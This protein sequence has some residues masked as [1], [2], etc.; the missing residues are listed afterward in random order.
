MLVGDA[1]RQVDPLTGGG[2]ING[3]TAGQLAGQVA[4]EALEHGDTSARGLAGYQKRADQTLGRQLTRNYRLRCRFP[5][6]QRTDRSFVRL[7]AVAAA[8]K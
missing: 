2:I 1:G 5:I 3:M 8:G 4:F 6:G 7:F